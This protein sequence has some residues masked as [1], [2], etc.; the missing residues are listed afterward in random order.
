M[1]LRIFLI[2][3]V[4]VFGCQQQTTATRANLIGTHDLVLVD[5]L[6]SPTTLAGISTD[7]DGVSTVAGVPSRYLFVTSAD[8]NELRI[9]ENVRTGLTGRNFVR[10][11]NPLESLSIPVL[12]RP[13]LLAA[14]EGRNRGGVR[15]TGAYVYAGRPGAAEVSVVSLAQRR[16]L[17]GRPMATPGPVTAMGAWMNVD[18]T[19][20]LLETPLPAITTLYVATWDGA[21]A[22]VYR[23]QIAT[24]S[25]ALDQL[26]WE[27]VF[28]VDQTPIVALRVVAPL[29]SRTLEGAPFCATAPCLALSTRFDSGKGGAS[30]LLDPATNRSTRLGFSGPVRY[31]TASNNA[32]RVYGILDEQACGSAACGGVVAVDL[33]SSTADGGFPA[34]LDALGLPMQPLRQGLGLITGLT[35]AAGG[36]VRQTTEVAAVDGGATV[37]NYA[38]QEYLELGAFASSTGYVTYFS[39][40]GGSII[41]FDARRSTVTSASTTVPGLL[42]DGGASFVGEDGGALGTFT[43]LAVSV[44]N[45]LSK[46]WRNVDVVTEGGTWSVDISDGYAGL[47]KRCLAAPC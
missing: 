34:A 2:G 45:D 44:D 36:R 24:D 28:L 4:F 30:L 32:A 40:F 35:V 1:K 5:Q 42:A 19:A 6:T 27:R 33:V 38:Y 46:T 20:P 43:S 7:V 37:I 23:A 10:A 15:V 16:Q 22:S 31:L 29:A 14:D 41:D 3:A 11:P 17:G 25:P 47:Y 13:T 12:D 8:T 21:F 26:T 39:G 9:L 18:A